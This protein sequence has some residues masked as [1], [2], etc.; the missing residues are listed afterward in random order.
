MKTP[1]HTIKP[2]DNAPDTYATIE[3]GGHKAKRG[4]VVKVEHVVRREQLVSL[5]DRTY[6]VASRTPFHLRRVHDSGWW[7]GLA[8]IAASELH[9]PAMIVRGEPARA[10]EHACIVTEPAG[11]MVEAWPEW[12][13]VKVGRRWMDFRPDDLLAVGPA[14]S[15]LDAVAASVDVG[16]MARGALVD[17]D[18]L[19]SL[20]EQGVLVWSARDA[21]RSR[22]RLITVLDR[23]ALSA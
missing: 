13:M 14:P 21:K 9:R 20:F 1:F 4:I 22:R 3:I 8:C 7:A 15:D 6:A 18:L 12:P 16:G 10:R 23:D 2:D 11:S 5:L 17:H 19:R